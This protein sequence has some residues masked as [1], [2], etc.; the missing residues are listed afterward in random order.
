MRL[1]SSNSGEM[2]RQRDHGRV[3]GQAQLVQGDDARVDGEAFGS[4]P[5]PVRRAR[6]QE[7]AQFQAER[8]D[9]IVAAVPAGQRVAVAPLAIR[10][11]RDHLAVE[12]RGPSTAPAATH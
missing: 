2:H 7:I 3:R 5:C 4:A 9:V 12:G 11:E 6:A 8:P 10:A 1:A